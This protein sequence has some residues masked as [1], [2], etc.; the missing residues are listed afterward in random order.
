MRPSQELSRPVDTEPLTFAQLVAS[1]VT[2]WRSVLLVATGVVLLALALTFV[3][4]PSYRATTSFVTADASIEL[5][6]ALGQLAS[7][8]GLSALAGQ[9]GVGTS[10]DPSYSPAFYYELLRS[11][12]VLTRLVQSRFADPRTADPSDSANLVQLFG[13]KSRD[14]LLAVE[15]AVR[16]LQRR[17]RVTIDL[18]TSFVSL[19]VDARWPTLAADIANHAVGLVS[20]FNKEQRVSR[21]QAKRE[22]LE[23]RVAAAQDELR[24]NE[25]ALRSFHETN[26]QWRESPGLS[27]EELRLGRQVQTA[28]TLYLLLRQQ[29]EA[30][31]LEEVNTTPLI[32]VVDRAVPPRRREWP[33]RAFILVTAALLGTLLGVLWAAAR[34]LFASWA[35]RNPQEA[36]LLR[37]AAVR[38]AHEVRGTLPARPRAVSRE[39]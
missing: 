27:I 21:A 28:S 30:A 39:H 13:I 9:L 35:E 5:P 26:R 1:T 36:S 31:R 18:K 19:Q 22:F 6:A 14:S 8:P 12:E 10:R 33:H 3:L 34:A 25:N 20:A 7:E 4:P 16:R 29:Y 24:T 23:G 15:L 32:T 17:S 38:M 11:R 2:R 37:S